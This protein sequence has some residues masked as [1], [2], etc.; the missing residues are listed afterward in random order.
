MRSLTIAIDLNCT[1]MDQIGEIVALSGGKLTRD[2][3][4][5]WDPPIG[6]KMGFSEEDFIDWAW[7]NEGLQINSAPFPGAQEA[8]IGLKNQGHKIKIV[9][10]TCMTP[11]K[12]VAWLQ[13]WGIPFDE[14]VF[15]KDKSKTYFDLLFDDCPEVLLEM[16]EK[17]LPVAKYS[18]GWNDQIDCPSVQNWLDFNVENY[19]PNE[20]HNEDWLIENL[21]YTSPLKEFGGQIYG[22]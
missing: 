18:T 2:D 5:Q 8:L 1:I 9:T 11:S 15:T 6:H 3:F 7:K 14:V 19:F 21:P 20:T 10:A 13:Y 4:D 12:V 22:V 16:I 17:G